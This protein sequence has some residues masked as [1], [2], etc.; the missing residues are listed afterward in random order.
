MKTI[1]KCAGLGDFYDKYSQYFEPYCYKNGYTN[2]ST[3]YRI[4]D[5]LNSIFEDLLKEKKEDDILALLKELGEHIPDSILNNEERY[6]VKFN[7]LCQLYKLLGLE[8]VKTEIGECLFGIEVGPYLTDRNQV[9][10]SFGMERWLRDK[11]QDVYDAYESALNSFSVGDLGLSIESCRTTLTGIFSKFKG[12]PFQDSKWQLGMATITGDFK[13][14]QSSDRSQMTAIKNEIEAMNKKDIAEFF[15]ENLNGNYKK[16]KAIY[17]IYSIMSDYG[18]H[19]MEGT[20]E[21]AKNEDALMMIRMTS[22]ILV[23]IYQKHGSDRK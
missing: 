4:F 12:V 21:V 3:S 18:T 9:I 14:T 10:Q 6:G 20:A 15:G 2:K 5:G 23:W 22:D 13:G 17:S 8:I 19:R 11:Y 7:K 1:L 16:T